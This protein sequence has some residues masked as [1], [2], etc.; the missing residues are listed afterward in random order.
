MSVKLKND[1]LS[2]HVLNVGDGDSIVIELPKED[3]NRCHIVVDCARADKTIDY[4]QKLGAT[5]L[6]L[7]VATHP[8][9][10][11]IDGLKA[12]MREYSNIEQ[13]WD[14]GF[15]HNSDTWYELIQ[16]LKDTRKDVIF[17]RPTSGMT[18]TIAGVEI[19]VIAP[20]IYM[21]NRYDTYGVNINNSSI[22][23]KLTYAD[24]SMILGADA[25]WDSW[26]KVTE[27]F[28]HYEK[29][30]NPEQHIKLEK[31]FNPLDCFFMKASHHGSKHGTA[32]EVAERLSPKHAAISCGK[33][34]RH[35]FP[36]KLAV[37]AFT[38][39][40]SNIRYTFNGTI[41]Y[42]I[43]ADGKTLS[44]QFT[45]GKDDFAPPPTRA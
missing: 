27:E 32:L 36:H 40:D 17:I 9:S 18:I 7:V 33:P 41:V 20:S 23:L 30:T 37:E 2:L 42:G 28:P 1:T 39:I 24:T 35:D 31:T 15:R 5:T 29:T 16:Y 14:S 12:V 43:G 21:R 13:F 44:D 34:S 4:L 8:H 10:D 25:Q 19:T 3:G 26:G 38:E 45:D 6:K 22:V 11:H